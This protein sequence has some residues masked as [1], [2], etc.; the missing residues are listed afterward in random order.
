M[1]L[2]T[3]LHQVPLRLSAYTLPDKQKNLICLFTSQYK[4]LNS[5]KQG[6]SLHLNKQG[7]KN[8]QEPSLRRKTGL[9]P[10]NIHTK[11]H[12]I[13]SEITL[14]NVPNSTQVF[15]CQN[16]NS[17]LILIWWRVY[18]NYTAI[19]KI[20]FIFLFLRWLT[21]HKQYSTTV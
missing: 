6:T 8:Y 21:P 19:Q 14:L 4:T 9:S 10:P 12:I 18:L 7:S 3:C 11:F 16:F 13:T 1:S 5:N 20:I 2:S 15:S 17:I